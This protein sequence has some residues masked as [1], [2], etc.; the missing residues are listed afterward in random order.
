MKDRVACGIV[1]F[2]PKDGEVQSGLSEDPILFHRIGARIQADST[3]PESGQNLLGYRN[4]PGDI[5]DT[6]EGVSRV[7]ELKNA[8]AF[9][10]QKL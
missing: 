9:A 8:V 2:L 6:E 5:L 4:V 1:S 7:H 3:I 10:R